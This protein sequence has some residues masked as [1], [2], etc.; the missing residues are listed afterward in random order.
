M[1]NIQSAL[2]EANKILAENNIKSS[3]LDSE[4]LLS[5]VLE[6]DRKFIILNLDKFLDN[7]H[8]KKFKNLISQRSSRKPIAYLVGKKDFW[9]YEFYIFDGTLIPRPE[10]ELIIEE[11]LR[12][13]KYKDKINILEIGIGSGCILLSIL[14]EKENFKG[15]GIDISK[16]CVELSKINALKLNIN[17][18]VKF[19]KSDVDNFFIGKYDLIISNPPYIKKHDLKY[20]ELDVAK[21]EPRLALDGGIDGVSEIIKVIDKSS[22][23]VKKGGKLILEINFNQGDKVKNILRRKGFF[24]NKVLKDLGKKDRCIV[25]TKL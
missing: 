20:L 14:K 8:Y 1:M 10:T 21:Y 5:K 23:L 2:L 12:I 17:H 7:I 13:F 4:I 24:I 19:F 6:K 9:K 25:S 11:A 15:V 3:K 22:K 18:R 16:K